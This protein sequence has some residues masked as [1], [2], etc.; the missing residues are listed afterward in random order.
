MDLGLISVE[1]PMGIFKALKTWDTHKKWPAE[2]E[3][4]GTRYQQSG[5]LFLLV[6]QSHVCL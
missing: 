6:T 1:V 2:L 4:Y 3:N 5:I